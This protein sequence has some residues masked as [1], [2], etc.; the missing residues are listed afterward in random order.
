[1]ESGQSTLALISYILWLNIA[2]CYAS[3]PKQKGI[4]AI[5]AYCHF[6][7]WELI[8]DWLQSHPESRHEHINR[9]ELKE[10]TMDLARN[11]NRVIKRIT[12]LVATC[13]RNNKYDFNEE[14]GRMITTLVE[15][16]LLALHGP[17]LTRFCDRFS[18]F[19][20]L[21]YAYGFFKVLIKKEVDRALSGYDNKLEEF[22]H[23]ESMKEAL[24]NAIAA[25]CAILDRIV[26]EYSHLVDQDPYGGPRLGVDMSK[27]THPDQIGVA[28]CDTFNKSQAKALRWI[29]DEIS[30]WLYGD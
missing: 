10:M 22:C 4:T 13:Y 17:R 2:D 6:S 5:Q 8:T 23:S 3:L 1:V 16:E 12:R 15:E 20:K 11:P 24:R 30:I 19:V 28:I 7:D 18:R 27:L 25:V 9:D 14:I 21:D 26:A 29:V